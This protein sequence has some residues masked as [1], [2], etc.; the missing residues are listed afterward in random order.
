MISKILIAT[1]GSKTA[2]KALEYAVELAKQTDA[3]IIV[4]AVIDKSLFVTRSIPSMM[5]PTHIREPLEDYLRQ[6]A[7][8][9]FGK[10]ERLF[11]RKGVRSRKVIRTG[12]PAEEILKEAQKSKADLIVVG[13]HGRSALK[14][15]VLGSVAFGVIH[16]NT[17]IPVLVVRR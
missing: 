9:D 3:T 12:H 7:E 11:R 16:K 4:L 8:T 13:S 2:W 6:V 10:V 5:T 14:A 1:D 17:K 15:A